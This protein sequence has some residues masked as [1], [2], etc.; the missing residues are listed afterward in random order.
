MSEVSEFLEGIKVQQEEVLKLKELQE[1]EGKLND[2]EFYKFNSN[3]DTVEKLKKVGDLHLFL[4]ENNVSSVEEYLENEVEGRYLGL[5]EFLSDYNYLVESLKQGL[6]S[7]VS[8]LNEL[9][10]E[11]VEDVKLDYNYAKSNKSNGSE[12]TSEDSETET[13]E[14]LGN[15]EGVEFKGFKLFGIEEDQCTCE[16]CIL[17]LIVNERRE[18][19]SG[20]TESEN[21]CNSECECGCEY[22]STEDEDNT[23]EDNKV[24]SI[25]D[26]HLGMIFGGC[27]GENSE[28]D[29]DTDYDT[30]YEDDTDEDY[31]EGV[32]V[33]GFE[34]DD[35][36]NISV[37]I[38]ADEIGGF[39]KYIEEQ[40]R[41]QDSLAGRVKQEQEQTEDTSKLGENLKFDEDFTKA[42][43]K[44][45]LGKELRGS[46]PSNEEI[47]EQFT[48][49]YTE[50]L[51][52]DISQEISSFKPIIQVFP[53]K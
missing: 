3:E 5:Q 33:I 17:D 28:C 2:P 11:V 46:T 15:V 43:L 10:P 23:E 53:F 4:S 29:Y 44:G 31:S 13:E 35:N 25:L 48:K 40:K 18:K 9:M 16:S 42:I 47:V 7:Y 39:L 20:E 50:K 37:N 30:D 45:I 12:D 26:K 49:H 34:E 27:C 19:L 51:S 6:D 22:D 24:E 52:K 36:G 8:T 21:E 32:E 41:E 1:T 14:A 38:D